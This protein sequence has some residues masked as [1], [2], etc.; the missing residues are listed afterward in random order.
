MKLLKL[1]RKRHCRAVF[2]VSSSS[3]APLFACFGA[4]K[5]AKR[6]KEEDIDLGEEEDDEEVELEGD[7]E[8][9]ESDG[10]DEDLEDDDDDDVNDE[11]HKQM[12]A[13]LD[14]LKNLSNGHK[15]R[16][17]ALVD[18]ADAAP[19]SE[20]DATTSGQCCCLWL[21]LLLL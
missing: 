5:S 11:R 20:H 16:P 4:M 12:L 18:E 7:D 2:V 1:E 13:Q 17:S 15:P 10:E 9:L 6:Q 14:V 19:E 3:H 21:L 8:E